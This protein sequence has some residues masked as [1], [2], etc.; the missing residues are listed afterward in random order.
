MAA[1]ERWWPC[2]RGADR[3]AALPCGARAEQALPAELAQQAARERRLPMLARRQRGQPALW[4]LQ[5]AQPVQQ[6]Q[7]AAL[8]LLPSQE[9]QGLQPALRQP[10]AWQRQARRHAPALP[11]VQ[12]VLLPRRPAPAEQQPP[13]AVQAQQRRRAALPQLCR[14][15]VWKQWQAPAAAEP[16]W[17]APGVVAE[18]CAVVPEGLEEPTQRPRAQVAA[19]ALQLPEQLADARRQPAW[20]AAPGRA[21]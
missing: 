11:S 4:R 13:P 1:G 12:V 5:R 16:R 6:L 8:E 21:A 7:Q 14:Q 10:L 19:R 17:A 2:K 9:A 18:R 15:E 3:S 20:R